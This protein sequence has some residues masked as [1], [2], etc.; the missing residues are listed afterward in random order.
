MIFE[1]VKIHSAAHHAAFVLTV[2]EAYD[3][4]PVYDPAAKPHWDALIHHTE[5]VLFKR[6][7]GSGIE[8]I[9]REDD[10]YVDDGTPGSAMKFMLYDMVMN[11][12]LMI[13]TGYSDNHPTFTEG[14]NVLLR[15]VHDFYTHGAIRKGFFEQLKKAAKELKLTSWPPIEKAGELLSKVNL[16]NRQFS[17]RGEFSATSD[18]IRLAPKAA[19]PAAFTE[20]TGQVSYQTVVGDF[21]AQ[22]VAVLAGFDYNNI[23]RCVP[24]SVPD[25]RMHELEEMITRGD[26]TIKLNIKAKPSITREEIDKMVRHSG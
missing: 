20:V 18:H 14:E 13:Y 8:I 2:A 10:P 3:A 22:K 12:R 5:K 16:K 23:G 25:K 6:L 24:G 15:A 26:Q 9:F 1:G 21:P 4:L 11:N 7:Q 17:A 19:A